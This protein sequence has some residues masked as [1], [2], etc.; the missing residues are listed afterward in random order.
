MIEQYVIG[1]I[2]KSDSSM[3]A[4]ERLAG[5]LLA[6]KRSESVMADW[7]LV[8]GALSTAAEYHQ[9]I[10]KLVNAACQL[11]DTHSEDRQKREPLVRDIM[12]YVEKLQTIGKPL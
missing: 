6:Q 2:M 9:I 7:K 10:E 12:W 3:V 11:V 1:G 8:K 5:F 4:I